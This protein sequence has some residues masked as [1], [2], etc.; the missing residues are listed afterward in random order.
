[1]PSIFRWF[2]DKVKAEIGRQI[3]GRMNATGAAVVEEARR[4]AP[5]GTGQLRDSI[6]Y[7]YRQSDK[8]LQIHADAPHAFYVEFGT[9]FMRARPYLRPALLKAGRAF[10]GKTE[11]QFAE[12]QSPGTTPMPKANA[13]AVAHNTASHRNYERRFGKKAPKVVFYGQKSRSLTGYKPAY[14]SRFSGGHHP[15]GM[16][17]ARTMS[18]RPRPRHPHTSAAA[19]VND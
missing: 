3:D 2:G 15:P 8:T 6:G 9:R 16:A 1:M 4:L 14:E 18:H 5:V 10:A 17:G 19:T 7:T 11:L 12:V 13:A